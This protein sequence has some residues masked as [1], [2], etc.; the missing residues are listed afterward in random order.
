MFHFYHDLHL[1]RLKDAS[2]PL[3]YARCK[4]HYPQLY[5]EI[6]AAVK[7]GRW[8]L[9]GAMW[10][11]ADCDI[12][13]G[14]SLI[15]QVIHGMNFYRDEFDVDV[16]NI[17]FPDV[18]GCCGNLPQI[19]KR[20]GI[21]YFLK[22]KPPSNRYTSSLHNT[23]IWRGI[24]GS[25]VLA[26]LHTDLAQPTLER[27]NT[28]RKKLSTWVGERCVERHRATLTSQADV[29]RWNR[30]AEEALRA[31]E[32]LCASTELENYPSAAFDELWKMLLANQF[33]GVVAGI[34]IRR[35]YTEAIQ[36][37]QAIVARCKALQTA[38][39]ETLLDTA[40]NV[41]TY[42][43]PSSTAFS[44][45]VVLPEG[46]KSAS[47]D[48][49]TLEGQR[50]AD[51][52]IAWLDVPAQGFVSVD[53]SKTE[54]VPAEAA[55]VSETTVL[56][57]DEVR[58]VL[59]AD[60]H[61]IS[62]FDKTVGIE[63][64]PAGLK[65][66]VISLFPELPPAYDAWDV[67]PDAVDMKS[68]DTRVLTIEVIRGPVRSGVMAFMTLGESTFMQTAWLG[69]TGK[70]LDFETT[71]DW[72]ESHKTACVSFPADV[73][74]N[75]ASFE[76]QYG[77][78]GRPTHDNTTWQTAQFEGGSHRYADVSE[79]SHGFALLNDSK[80]GCRV[81]DGV[82]TLSLFCAPMHPDM[83]CDLGQHYFIYSVLPHEGALSAS[84]TV[85]ANAAMINQGLEMFVG[86]RAGTRAVLPVSVV[87]EGIELAVIKRAEKEDCLIVRLVEC[88][89]R[90]AQCEL[91]SIFPDTVFVPCTSSEW[92]ETGDGVKAP[93][94]LK[95]SPYEIKTFK[96]FCHGSRLQTE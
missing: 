46:W 43:N 78:V 5:E 13:S 50:E 9:K 25:E 54:P 16:K 70:R 95:F 61:I 79:P 21:E 29:K 44:G 49:E 84:D 91:A 58:Y 87:G 71:V 1:E 94:I 36:Q 90:R 82:M 48:G 4:E 26:R 34:S 56:E 64:I 72:R 45:I 11:D 47:V 52:Y 15:R 41:A 12:P 77:T 73:Y 7:A 55:D 80:Y 85:L 62:C 83:A 23:F 19:L 8:E 74:A 66:N 89:G 67:E 17:L 33:H 37:L 42:F 38:A 59:D 63:L 96:V 31:A 51:V 20:A 28:N 75:E 76:I 92:T 32:M 86:R 14:E 35:V 39:A 53:L 24:D 30:R 68:S 27:I 88:R 81:K 40:E 65:G 93:A 2:S 18:F 6:K 22:Q 60:L 3:L 10:A 69:K 57:N